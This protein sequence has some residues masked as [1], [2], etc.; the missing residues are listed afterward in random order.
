MLQY[1]EHLLVILRWRSEWQWWPFARC[2]DSAIC[3]I[4]WCGV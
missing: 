3:W 4:Q 2:A 1:G